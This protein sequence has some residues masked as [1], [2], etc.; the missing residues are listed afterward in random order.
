MTREAL[1]IIEIKDV[2]E[3]GTKGAQVLAFKAR[4]KDGKIGR[5][6][7]LTP[8]TVPSRMPSSA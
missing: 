5:A 4:G 1:T 3:V 7:V 8:V 2:K 6:H